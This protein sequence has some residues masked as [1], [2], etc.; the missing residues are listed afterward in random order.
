MIWSNDKEAAEAIVLMR[1]DMD[2]RLYVGNIL[3]SAYLPTR[4]AIVY[5][6]QGMRIEIH[7]SYSTVASPV[8]MVPAQAWSA[9]R[10]AAPPD[11]LGA[12]SW[13][14]A[15]RVLRVCGATLLGD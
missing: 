13:R 5:L 7:G 14:L 11:L 4:V 1:Y 6:C 2:T 10:Y 9:G 8:A 15:A 12:L 3:T